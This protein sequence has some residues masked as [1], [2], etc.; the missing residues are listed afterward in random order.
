MKYNEHVKL[1]RLIQANS[2]FYPTQTG[3][4]IISGDEDEKTPPTQE[5]NGDYK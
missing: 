2:T 1:F 5:S 3:W 4:S